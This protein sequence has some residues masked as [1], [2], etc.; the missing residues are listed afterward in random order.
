MPRKSIPPYLQRGLLALIVVLMGISVAR[1]LVTMHRQQ[2]RIEILEGQVAQL[3]ADTTRLV[4]P[5]DVPTHYYSQ[6]G[7]Y[8]NDNYYRS[9]NYHR[10]NYSRDY[11]ANRNDRS[12]RDN[13]NSTPQSETIVRS[14]TTGNNDLARTN[15]VPPSNNGQ[16]ADTQQRSH[17][18]TEPH[19]FDLNTIDSATLTRI[20]GIAERTASV[21]LKNRQRYGG[22]YSPR[23]LAEFLTWDAAQAYMDEWCNAWFTADAAHIRF[24]HINSATVSELQRHPYISY[25]QAIE[26]IRYRSRHSQIQSVSELQQL[27][28]F[29]EAQ[30][31]QLLPYLSFD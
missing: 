23:Q 28:T 12:N 1:L 17:K 21:I 8:R 2:E 27:S 18:L 11:R 6:R 24:I 3:L 25:E 13:Y 10:N 26:L 16:T 20:P 5:A 7:S 9:D 22:F 15:G 4:I 31:K 14:D 19:L 29:S 30:L